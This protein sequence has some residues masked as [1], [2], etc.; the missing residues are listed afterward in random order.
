MTR[1]RR[2]AAF[3]KRPATRETG[4][5]TTHHASTFKLPLPPALELVPPV[6]GGNGVEDDGVVA[7]DGEDVALSVLW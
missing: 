1:R 2:E 7:A 4:P 3:G 6:V 5:P